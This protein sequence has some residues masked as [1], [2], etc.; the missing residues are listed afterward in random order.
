MYKIV[1]VLFL[2]FTLAA[3]SQSAVSEP[4]ALSTQATRLERQHKEIRAALGGLTLQYLSESEYP[5]VYHP[6]PKPSFAAY[7]AAW[8]G[9]DVTQRRS[10]TEFFRQ[11]RNPLYTDIDAERYTVLEQTLRRHLDYLRIYWVTDPADPYEVQIVILGKN[12]FGVFA[13][14][15]IS[16]ET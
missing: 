11:L 9:K 6:V 13:L 15:T 8:E 14:S 3:C 5:W 2:A 16:I 12:R 1:A 7:L 4:A 10:F